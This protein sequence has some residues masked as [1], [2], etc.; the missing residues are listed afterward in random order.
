MV[1][2][3]RTAASD[4]SAVASVANKELYAKNIIMNKNVINNISKF[5]F[6]LKFIN[7][8]FIYKWKNFILYN[9]NIIKYKFIYYKY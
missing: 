5:I 9:L 1:G 4:E 8:Y 7:R 2:F 3:E 6:I